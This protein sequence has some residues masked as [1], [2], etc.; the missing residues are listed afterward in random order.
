[1]VFDWQCQAGFLNIDPRFVEPYTLDPQ[2]LH[3]GSLN[4]AECNISPKCWIIL[5]DGLPHFST[6]PS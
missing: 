6:T 4:L 2:P 1:M 3:V 5:L